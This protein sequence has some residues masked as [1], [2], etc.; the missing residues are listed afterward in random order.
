MSTAVLGVTQ[1]HE[2]A[3]IVSTF[4]IAT[5]E[6]ATSTMTP[7]ELQ[8]VRQAYSDSFSESMMVCAIVG[9]ACVLGSCLTWNRK[10]IDMVAVG[11][12]MREERIEAAEGSR[13]TKEA[14]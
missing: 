2:L 8:T 5:L 1:R 11:N 4:Q 6:T 14:V 13:L 9:G 12:A 7:E 3:G 10:K